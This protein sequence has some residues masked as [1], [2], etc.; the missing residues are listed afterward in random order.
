MKRI[1]AALL[2]LRQYL[3]PGFLVLGVVYTYYH[4]AT[5]ERGLLVWYG[6]SKQVAQLEKNNVVM[7][8]KVARLQR[9]V[10]RLRPETF[11]PDFVDELVRATLPVV[12]PEE[13]MLLVRYRDS[14]GFVAQGPLKAAP[15][16]V[17]R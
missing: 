3:L 11:D 14:N 2:V 16:A 9:R 10:D 13:E 4:L 1:H 5:G 12:R 6:L 7:K 17:V 15:V 8:E